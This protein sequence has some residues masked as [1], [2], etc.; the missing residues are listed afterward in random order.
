VEKD[1]HF[2]QFIRAIAELEAFINELWA[3]TEWKKSTSKN[4]S[5]VLG[6]FR[7]RIRKYNKDYET[8]LADFK[9][10][11]DLYPEEEKI[12]T[13][14]ES[15]S[16]DEGSESED[17]SSDEDESEDEKPPKAAP[18]QKRVDKRVLLITNKLRELF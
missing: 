7:Q 3:D 11:P 2:K 12:V 5:G 15:G 9:A 14:K 17:E 6:K 10:H 16:E 8:E 4:N 1:G 13:A 18:K